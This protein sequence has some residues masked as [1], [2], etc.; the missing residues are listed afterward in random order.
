MTITDNFMELVHVKLLTLYDTCLTAKGGGCVLAISSHLISQLSNFEKKKSSSTSLCF[1]IRLFWI[2]GC[3]LLLI[4]K[5]M[6]NVCTYPAIMLRA[7]SRLWS[8]LV[9][10]QPSGF[11]STHWEWSQDSSLDNRAGS[12]CSGHCVSVSKGCPSSFK[13]CMWA[14]VLPTPEGSEESSELVACF[15]PR[16]GLKH[17]W[18]VM[19]VC[20]WVALIC[21]LFSLLQSHKW[22]RYLWTCFNPGCLLSIK[23]ILKHMH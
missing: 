5:Q 11:I 22:F 13:G 12:Y 20:V 2:P 10:V 4:T 3:C 21:I 1:R 15:S 19:Y 14:G 6:C 23:H 7:V 16:G 17:L 9:E 18:N 8:Y